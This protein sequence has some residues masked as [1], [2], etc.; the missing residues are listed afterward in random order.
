MPEISVIIVNWNGKHLLEDCLDALRRQTFRDF[1]AILVD[2]GSTDAS[3]EY[4]LA[5]YP[6]VRLLALEENRGFTGGNIAG[7]EIASGS[8]IVLLNNDTE[9]HP[10]WLQEMHEAAAVHPAV[11]SFASKM[12][13]F[14]DRQRIENCGFE[15]DLAGTTVEVGRGQ[16]D[17]PE[18]STPR[19]VFGACGGAVAYRRSMLERIGFLDPDFFMIYEDVDLSFR[20]QL[21]GHECVYLPQAIV[22]HRYRASIGRRP[23]LQ[24]FYA[25][26]NID[27]VYL[28]NLPLGLILRSAPRRLIY[29]AGAAL[30]FV[31]LGK[32]AAFLR[33]KLDVLRQ[34]PVI[35]E[36]RRI[37]QR[38]RVLTNSQ[39]SRIMRGRSLTSKFRKFFSG[40]VGSSRECVPFQ[41]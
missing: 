22:Y 8:L 28:K 3:A 30:H 10:G 41:P 36:K 32:G 4:V 18:W 37:I 11:G 26:R 19:K 24:V 34:L 27:F 14:D 23:T 9:A 31:A 40:L 2:N 21:S 20:A 35:L 13:Y 5:N 1:E 12:M 33:A 6:E 25:Q 17:G 7:Y 29:E 38:H 16:V 15:I 39:L